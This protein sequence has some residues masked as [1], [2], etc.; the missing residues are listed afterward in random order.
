MNNYHFGV[1]PVN[2]SDSAV[3]LCVLRALASSGFYKAH[4][5]HDCRADSQCPTIFNFR[6]GDL[7]YK[8][9]K[10]PFT[11]QTV[12]EGCNVCNLFF[13]CLLERG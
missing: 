11:R 2:F 8:I 12:C 13:V 3:V 5:W 9:A 7:S 6:Y 10:N 4:F 1:S